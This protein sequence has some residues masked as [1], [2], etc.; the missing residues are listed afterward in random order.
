M[1]FDLVIVTAAND[2]QAEGYRAQV[3]PLRGVL[4]ADIL[5]EPDP[6]GRRVGSLGSTV[7]VLRKYRN[8]CGGRR[9][10]ICHSGGDSKRL[11]AYA[12]VG[13]A[14]VPISGKDGSVRTL[15][16]II[17]SNMGR[18][19]LP[20][21]GVLVVC[22]DVAPDF[23]FAICDFSR[24][25]VTG[26]GYMDS[27]LEGSRHGVYVPEKKGG[28]LRGVKGFLQK[29][30][31][32]AAAAGG[33]LVRG[34]VAVDTGIL[35]IDGDT[36]ERLADSGWTEGDIY[37][38]F[39]YALVDGFA[40]FSVNLV[41][42]CS[43]FHVGSSQELLDKLGGG[44]EWVEGCEI[45]RAEMQL[46]G[47]NIV[48]G[49]PASYGKVDLGDGECLLSLPLGD[50][51]WIH[52]KYRVEDTFKTDGKWEAKD[53][54]VNGKRLSFGE[55]M[56][57]VNQERAASFR[58]LSSVSV[59]KPL[60]IDFAGGW[61]DTP[62]ICFEKGGCVFNA[63]VKLGGIN[64]VKVSVRRIPDRRVVVESLDLGKR[65]DYFTDSEIADHSDPHDWCAL[66]KSALTVAGYRIADGGLHIRLSAAVPKG[67]GLGTSSILGA[68]LLEA[69]CRIS[70]R[71]CTWEEIAGLTL[72]LEQ[73]MRT[74][75][76]WQDQAGGILPGVKLISSQPGEPQ[77][78]SVRTL[79][80]SSRIAFADF[81]KERALL[82]FTGRKRMARNV[83]FGVVSFYRENPCGIAHAIIDRLKN[84]AENAF[85]AVETQD[86]AAFCE[87]MNGYWL[88][89]KALDPGSTNQLVETVIA[90]IA[91]WTSA[92]SLCG[93][94]G[95]G[96]ML[97]IAR[98]AASRE[99]VRNVLEVHSPSKAG[100]IFDFELV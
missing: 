62:P 19:K 29:P 66:A 6:G 54:T 42:S 33:A 100:R 11:P 26:V 4:A 13:K 25:G 75:G 14:F 85:R 9:V 88:S 89:K 22:G 40:P 10:L 86:W 92:V 57:L 98:D 79:G 63:A 50:D 51:D 70:G 74:G 58:R 93:A 48:T 36:S 97:I 8:L 15:F 90:R 1:F 99:R 87:A 38:K 32:K 24:P 43:F 34:R 37:E 95:G 82:F 80:A 39:T 59:E 84:D 73:E 64:P 16:E 71:K 69:L 78:L 83:L 81:L 28:V 91:P 67:S 68:A 17:V 60:R 3:E 2:A 55:L 49:V 18:L 30:D 35:W 47:R 46:A 52:V 12:A 56:P 94:G 31:E 23:K 53:Y 77:R 20:E 72:R 27:M 96:F 44:V 45:P 61:S 41:P 21:S 5:V 65:G 7:N 76:G